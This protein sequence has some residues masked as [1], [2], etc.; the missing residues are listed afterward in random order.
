MNQLFADAVLEEAG[1]EPAL[2]FIQDYHFALLPRMLKDRN[3]NLIM[4]QFWHI[5]WP[6]AEIF[7]VFPWG[8]EMLDGMLGNDLLGFH[9]RY[10]SRN[11]AESVRMGIE[12]RADQTGFDLT[13]NGHTT[14]V[15]AFPISIDFDEFAAL[16]DSPKSAWNARSG[17]AS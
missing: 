5:P 15:R 2:V 6:N 3:P 16:G 4:A 14:L 7:R 10:H 11:F 12:A 13:R 8:E 17:C 9:L 1:D